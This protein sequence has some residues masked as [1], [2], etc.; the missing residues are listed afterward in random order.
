MHHDASRY[1]AMTISNYS[2]KLSKVIGLWFTV[3]PGP[4]ARAVWAQ[5]FG[6]RG[7]P[8]GPVGPVKPVGPAEPV[9]P[10]KVGS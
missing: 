8:V 1:P 10:A 6:A 7:G 3:C 5:G 9:E 2:R 4:R